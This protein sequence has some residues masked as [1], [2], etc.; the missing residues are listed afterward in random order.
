[1]AAADVARSATAR[2][3]SAGR[4]AAALIL[5]LASCLA[6]GGLA[7]SA[8]ARGVRDWYPAL[9]KPSWT[10]P[11]AVFAPVWTVLYVMM[12]VAAWQVWREAGHS[13]RGAAL[14]LFAIQ[15]ALD[16]AWSF[17]FFGMRSVGGGL[18]DIVLLLAAIIATVLAFRRVRPPAALLLLPYLA[19]V[20]YATALNVAIWRMN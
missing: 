8:T 11:D 14:A 2:R 3:T 10:P 20:G 9:A 15:L 12:A 17:F 5:V 1:M 6:V 18:A 19:W 13:G 16:C 7:A 4:S